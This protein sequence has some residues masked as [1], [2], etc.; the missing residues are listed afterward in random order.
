GHFS[1]QS[2]HGVSMEYL[3]GVG[4]IFSYGKSQ[5]RAGTHL[6]T[7]ANPGISTKPVQLNI[8]LSKSLFPHP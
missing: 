1:Q 2:S 3:K 7:V 6:H 5:S 8:Q 4:Y